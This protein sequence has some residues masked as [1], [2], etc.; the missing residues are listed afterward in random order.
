MLMKVTLPIVEGNAAVADGSL[1][2]TIASSA[3]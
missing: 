2:A 1:G 3:I